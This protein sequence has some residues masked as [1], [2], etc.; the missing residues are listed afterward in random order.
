MLC[1]AF[2]QLINVENMRDADKLFK[3]IINEV[4][5]DIS[6]LDYTNH[7]VYLES[8]AR[9]GQR[10]PSVRVSSVSSLSGEGA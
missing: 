8:L 6:M 3:R 9:S 7:R 1:A 4:D 10:K 5:S 2:D